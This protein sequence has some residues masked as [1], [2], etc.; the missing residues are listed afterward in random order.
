M[1]EWVQRITENPEFTDIEFLRKLPCEKLV[2]L[3]LITRA[4]NE[5]LKKKL[6]KYQSTTQINDTFHIKSFTQTTTS[7]LESNF[8]LR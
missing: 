8:N 1:S 5:D 6:N 4:E 7:P 3:L 2:D